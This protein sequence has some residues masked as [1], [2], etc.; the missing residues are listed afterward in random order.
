MY[1][2]TLKALRDNPPTKVNVMYDAQ[3]GKVEYQ[4]IAFAI[5]TRT[6]ASGAQGVVVSD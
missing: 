6:D 3:F 5:T 2:R 1:W 4:D